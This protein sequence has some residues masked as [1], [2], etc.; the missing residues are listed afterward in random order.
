MKKT[1]KINLPKGMTIKPGSIDYCY[2]NDRLN[3]S[4][5]L[6]KERYEPKDGDVVY[7]KVRHNDNDAIFIYKK[8]VENRI[9]GY[10]GYNIGYD[11]MVDM[12]GFAYITPNIIGDLIEYRPATEKEKKLLFDK[13][14][15][16]G[17]KWNPE[18]KNIEDVRWRAKKEGIYYHIISGDNDFV[19]ASSDDMRTLMD[20]RRYNVGNYFK[21]REA[22]E[23]VAEQI[24]EI[25]RNSKA[26]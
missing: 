9:Y 20:E 14:A 21:T 18:T 8:T 6:E 7:A 5:E 22:A 26:E 15:E 12:H 24:R 23:K 13:L 25:L 1:Y 10:A 4:V 19:I 11:K 3:I 17:K 16:A 2:D